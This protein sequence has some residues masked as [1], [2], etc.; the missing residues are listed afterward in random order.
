MHE[1]I[2]LQFGQQANYLG[3]HYWNTQESYFTY[4]NNETSTEE[5]S[6]VN[7]D[8][9][10][11]PGLAPDGSDTYTPRTLLY[12]LKGAFG[13][14]RRENALYEITQDVDPLQQNP[15]TGSSGRGRTTEMRLPRIEPSPY[16]LALD[17]GGELP[18]LN[19]DSVRFWSDYNHVFYHP[20]SIVQ[21]NEYEVNSSLMPFERFATGE[22]LFA[23]LDREHDLLDRDLR[24]FLEECDHF[25]G[26]QIFSSTDDAWGG[27]TARYLERVADE[28]GKCSRWVFASEEGGKSAN[29]TRERRMLQLANS[30]QAL[31]SVVP[32]ASLY[33]PVSTLPDVLP[34]NVSVDA[35]SRWHTSALQAMIVESLTLPARLKDDKQGQARMGELEMALGGDG[36]RPIVDASLSVSD[37]ADLDGAGAAENTPDVRIANRPTNGTA[38]RKKPARIDFLP[39][40]PRSISRRTSLSRPKTFSKVESARGPWHSTLEIQEANL[41]SRD[42]Y[43]AGARRI[44]RQTPLLYPVL[45][46]SP[47]IF[48]SPGQHLDKIAVATSLATST[49]VAKHVRDMAGF[50]RGAW[51]VEEREAVCDGLVGVAE[52]YEEGFSDLESEGSEEDE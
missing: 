8:I 40:L 14:L 20:R 11:R 27:F 23:N 24:P 51:A 37:P 50:V 5:P 39:S 22:E 9:S 3:T 16:Q 33:I 49:K 36:R 25:Q 13:T 34:R 12:D 47:K 4:N 45:S 7:H 1:I 31:S 32:N 15:W 6:P 52:E 10:F 38:E 29:T 21:L 19:T 18:R 2:T 35:S 28:L 17:A 43:A 46:S 30:A 44:I 41:T 48:Q 42:R 26:L